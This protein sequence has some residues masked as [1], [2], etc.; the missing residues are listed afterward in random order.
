[1]SGF[2]SGQAHNSEWMFNKCL[3]NPGNVYRLIDFL[4][5]FICVVYIAPLYAKRNKKL[6]FD[7][8]RKKITKINN[9]LLNRMKEDKIA[10]TFQ[11]FWT[12]FFLEANKKLKK[13][14]FNL[15][16]QKLN[17]WENVC[18]YL[19][20][21]IMQYISLILRFIFLYKLIYSNPCFCAT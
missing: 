13:V 3:A 4:I 18:Q 15:I 21:I 19:V 12:G 1:M 20:Y 6:L 8:C 7:L 2:I 10:T 14:A 17:F 5:F 11:W 9:H 16:L